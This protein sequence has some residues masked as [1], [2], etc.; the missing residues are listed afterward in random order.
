MLPFFRTISVGGVFLAITLLGLALT[1]PGTAHLR[2]VAV[3]APAS[4]AL[5]DQG[6]HPEWR[7]FIM[8]AALRRAYAINA[9]RDLPDTPEHLPEIP[10]VAPA[11]TPPVFPET[12]S[13]GSSRVAGLSE[14]SGGGPDEETGSM[15]GAPAA[16][17]IDIGESSSAELPAFSADDKPPPI[18]MP[19]TEIPEQA[20]APRAKVSTTEAPEQFKP[21]VEPRK[22]TARHHRAIRAKTATPAAPAAVPPPFNILEAIFASLLEKPPA[23]AKPASSGKS[24]VKAKRL[25]IIRAVSQ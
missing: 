8:R 22:R 1:P 10:N 20:P 5:I 11:Y 13:G 4:G 2:Y 3:D 6:T 9:L 25:K 21:P 18:R 7:Q 24:H 16:I 14:R 17:P 12:P 19:L 23:A 15:G